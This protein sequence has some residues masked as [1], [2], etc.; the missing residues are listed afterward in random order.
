MNLHLQPLE[1]RFLLSYTI[2]SLGIL[3]GFDGCKAA[4]LNNLG[5]AVGDCYNDQERTA[6]PYP[7]S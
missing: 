2:T 1:D 6:F 5:Q 7:G 3:P 4:A